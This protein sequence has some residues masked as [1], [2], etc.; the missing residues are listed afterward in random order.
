MKQSLSQDAVH[1][2]SFI[3]G[4]PFG[5]TGRMVRSNVPPADA[6]TPYATR[7]SIRIGN[8]G[9]VVFIRDYFSR[10]GVASVCQWHSEQRFLGRRCLRISP[11]PF[12]AGKG[13]GDD[14]GLMRIMTSDA[15][16]FAVFIKRQN[17][18]ILTFECAHADLIFQGGFYKVRFACRMSVADIVAALTKHFKTADH[19]D[20]RKGGAAFIRFFNV[21]KEALFFHD[22]PRFIQLVVRVQPLVL[23][24]LVTFETKS[25]AIR[26]GGSPQG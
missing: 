6:R 3:A 8:G 16:D 22:V 23:L 4:Q 9:E 26:I 24:L 19:F 21:T 20:R 18:A 10:P 25:R 1:V 11:R 5:K 15:G 12:R 17:D 14:E 7:N 13:S 2:L